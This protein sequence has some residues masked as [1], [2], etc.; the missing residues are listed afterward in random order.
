MKRL[1]YE[2][3]GLDEID[4]RLLRLLDADG[5]T[6]IADL[7]RALRLSSPSVAERM[8][9]LEEAGVI[10]RVTVDVDPAA[11][12]YTLCV[13]IRIRPST[14]QLKRVADLLAD[15]PQIIECDRITG[16]DCFIARACLR[17][18][19]ELEQLIDRIIPYARTNT[20]IIQ[21]SPVKRRLPP[22]PSPQK[23]PASKNPLPTERVG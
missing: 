7:A 3:G 23:R 12:G 16:D 14:G 17:S 8:K 4:A 15:T 9:R 13:F 22:L 6:S 21:S 19:E 2:N 5:R 10:R 1:R 20:S 11:L 18:V